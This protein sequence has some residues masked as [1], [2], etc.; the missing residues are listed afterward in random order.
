MDVHQLMAQATDTITVKRVFGESIERDGTLVIPVAKVRGGVGGGGSAPD[1]AG[2]GGLGLLAAPV[3]V[4]SVRDGAVAW[5][6]ALD[7]NRII[8]G[9]QLVG[10]AL[11]LTVRSIL[12]HRRRG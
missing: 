10:V 5:H 2:G 11:L 8:L 4:Y 12:A 3:G 7:L 6:P 9:G 1:E